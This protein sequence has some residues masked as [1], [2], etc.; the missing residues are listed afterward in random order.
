MMI[1]LLAVILWVGAGPAL[2]AG[3]RR[4]EPDAVAVA[5]KT[6]KTAYDAGQ[7]GDAAATLQALLAACGADGRT[8]LPPATQG[9]VANDLAL[10]QHRAG[11]DRGCLETLLDYTPD[12]SPPGPSLS[13]LSPAL[14]RAMQFNWKLCLAACDGAPSAYDAVCASVRA[15]RETARMTGGFKP[16]ACKLVPDRAAIGLPDGT[17]MTMLP[18]HKPF[19]TTTADADDPRE[20]C[21]IPALIARRNGSVT[22][23][24]LDTPPRS[25]LRSPEHCCDTIRLGVDGSGRI[26]AEPDDNP[27]EGC[28]FGH[29]TAVMQDIFRVQGGRLRLVGQLSPPWFP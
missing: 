26:A 28:L 8:A 21:P 7:F 15:E 19:D 18:S 4:C 11:D 27:P 22:T 23:T 14:Q 12:A 13:A 25:F 2:A 16:V 29:R 1:P 24:P 20:I 5:R 10:A 9:A 6:F 17:C 3:D